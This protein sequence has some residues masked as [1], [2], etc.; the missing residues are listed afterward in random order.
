VKPL[1]LVFISWLV[2]ISIGILAGIIFN[3]IIIENKLLRIFN[4]AL[5]VIL[6]TITVYFVITMKNLL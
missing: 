3:K 2:I 4:I 5:G 1:F 6:F